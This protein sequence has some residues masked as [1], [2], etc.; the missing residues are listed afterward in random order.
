VATSITVCGMC[1]GNELPGVLQEFRMSKDALV[2]LR[3]PLQQQRR[4]RSEWGDAD[5]PDSYTAHLSVFDAD[6]GEDDRCALVEVNGNKVSIPQEPCQRAGSYR[7]K[8]VAVTNYRD[9]LDLLDLDPSAVNR[10]TLRCY[11]SGH[12]ACA[13][14]YVVRERS[15]AELVAAVRSFRNARP[16][17]S[18]WGI[19]CVRG[20]ATADDDDDGPGAS[21]AAVV[22]QVRVPLACPLS[23]ARMRVPARGSGCSHE[24]CFD[25]DTFLQT[26]H[27]SGVWECPICLSPCAF[28]VRCRPSYRRSYSRS[29]EDASPSRPPLFIADVHLTKFFPTPR[30]SYHTPTPQHRDRPSKLTS[31]SR[32]RCELLLRGQSVQW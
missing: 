28:Q 14:I 5:V 2:L 19:G 23:L 24:R 3:P 27:R 4:Q 32:G 31:G 20:T 26:C 6:T 29:F 12:R 1:A 9:V 30:Y 11:R 22:D 13:I 17:G 10:A 15:Q 25:L 16:P 7:G 18:R 21:S 8:R